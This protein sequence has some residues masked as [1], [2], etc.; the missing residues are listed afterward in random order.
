[1]KPTLQFYNPYDSMI[2][3]GHSSYISIDITMYPVH[4]NMDCGANWSW[5][6]KL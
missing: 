6:F 1:M 5:I 4:G 3:H 2:V